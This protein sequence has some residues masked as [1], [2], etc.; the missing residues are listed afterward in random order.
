MGSCPECSATN[1]REAKT[2]DRVTMKIHRDFFKRHG[3][4]HFSVDIG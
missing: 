1:K 4:H 2:I 3:C